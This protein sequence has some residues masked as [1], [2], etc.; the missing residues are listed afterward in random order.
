MEHPSIETQAPALTLLLALA[1]NLALT[2]TRWHPW[3][4]GPNFVAARKAQRA[5]AAGVSHALG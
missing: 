5:E 2:L 4:L 3:R 1:L